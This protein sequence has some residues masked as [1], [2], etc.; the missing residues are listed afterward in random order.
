MKT[1]PRLLTRLLSGALLLAGCAAGPDYR[2]PELEVPQTYRWQETNAEPGSF[3]DLGWWSV[4]QD[5]VLKQ[6]I[7]T[8]LAQN[9]D[10]R[11][12]A[13]RVEQA[14]ATL[15]SS[16]LQLLPAITIGGGSTRTQ[17]S[18]D[19]IQPGAQRLNDRDSASVDLSYELDLWGRLRRSNEAARADL[20]A[21][22][23]AQR[24]VMAGLVADVATA[25]FT[26]VSLDEQLKITRRTVT[27]RQQFYD[28]TRAQFE[29]G[30]ISGL[31]VSTAEAQLS[32]AQGNVPDLERQIGLSE[33]QLS[34]LLGHNPESILRNA[35][36][37]LSHPLP[38]QTQAGL[39]AALLERRPDLL[40]AEQNLIAAN[41][42]VGVAKAALFPAISLT[43]ALGS[44]STELSNLFTAPAETWSLGV[45]LLQPLLS[46]ERNLYQ[47]ELA[48]ARKREALLQYQKTVQT[49]F[50]EVADA[51]IGRQKFEEFQ[52]AQQTQVDALS[53]AARIALERYKVGYSSY[54]DVIN[55]DRDLFTAELALSNAYRNSL[56]ATVQ[57]Y[58]A[59]GGGW[60]AQ[61]TE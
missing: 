25:Y 8:A 58:R 1:S 12:A 3:G 44:V 11:I 59:L 27:A 26:V 18:S 53:N 46:A 55:A 20:L 50:K 23:F 7:E 37:T 17:S 28:L 57:I 14:R 19:E 6:L 24:S 35:R 15:G 9:L 61:G 31:D 39:P 52:R 30:V 10:V 45:G 42:R 60:Q 54:F 5:P 49:A 33:N 29:R 48:D 16:R 56:Q 13:T 21:S 22:R 36:E 51:L 4:Y 34:I 41:A 2:R 40:Q 43:G 47:V 32:L 38:L